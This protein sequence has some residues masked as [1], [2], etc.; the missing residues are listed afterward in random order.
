MEQFIDKFIHMHQFKFPISV[1]TFYF[2]IVVVQRFKILVAVNSCARQPHV[3]RTE[4]SDVLEVLIFY[5][6]HNDV[7]LGLDLQHLQRQAQERRGLDIPAV[8]APHVLQLHGL[9]HHQLGREAEAFLFPILG[10]VNAG[11]N[12]LLHEVLRVGA[13]NAMRVL[14]RPVRHGDRH[15]PS[16]ARRQTGV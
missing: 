10:L 12:D 16:S 3:Q 5:E 6:L 7:L 11:A 8:D 2:S 1:L 9:V 13:V 14:H 4:H 15:R